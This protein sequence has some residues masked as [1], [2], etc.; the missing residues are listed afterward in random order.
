MVTAVKPRVGSATTGALVDEAG[1][2]AV[3]GSPVAAATVRGRGCEAATTRPPGD[4]TSTSA[5]SPSSASASSAGNIGAVA[6]AKGRPLTMKCVSEAD[7]GVAGRLPDGVGV[8]TLLAALAGRA[9]AGCEGV[10]TF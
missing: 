7:R 3:C 2:A 5:S 10:R 8:R 1:P 4:A 9:R 6:A